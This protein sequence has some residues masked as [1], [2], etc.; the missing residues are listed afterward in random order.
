MGLVSWMR[1]LERFFLDIRG[2][3]GYTSVILNIR[4]SR[5]MV[6]MLAFV[7]HRVFACERSPCLFVRRASG[8]ALRTRK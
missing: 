8:S 3:C 1:Q 4:Y 6:R 2:M 5:R 7:S